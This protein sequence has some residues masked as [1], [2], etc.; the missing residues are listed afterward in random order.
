MSRGDVHTSVKRDIYA[1]LRDRDGLICGICGES[2]EEQWERYQLWLSSP[3][4]KLIKRKDCDLTIDHIL[5]KSL[6]R[7]LPD[8]KYKKGW[9]YSDRA[10]LQLSHLVCNNKK[11][12][13]A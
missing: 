12:N 7:K 13:G 11:G 6:V 10:N 3:K 2:I 1:F 9:W 4:S 5:P 8:W